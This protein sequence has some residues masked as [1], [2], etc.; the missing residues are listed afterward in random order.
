MISHSRL[1]VEKCK[2]LWMVGSA[3]LT[4]VASST[5]INWAPEITAKASPRC[6]PAV[7]LSSPSDAALVFSLLS[8]PN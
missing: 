4:M 5:I 1:A 8:W 2:L 6:L 7:F 3:T